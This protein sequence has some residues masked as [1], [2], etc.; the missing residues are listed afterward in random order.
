MIT[1]WLN[2]V[3]T[4]TIICYSGVVYDP[5]KPSTSSVLSLIR[6]T[7]Q[8]QYLRVTPGVYAV[9]ERKF[10]FPEVDHTDG[11]GTKAIY[12]WKKKTF[13][14]A[15]LDSLA[16]NLNDLLLVGAK[17]YKLQNHLVLPKDDS[18]I[19]K[20]IMKTLVAECK[21]RE[22]AITGGET[23]VHS[24]EESFDIGITVSGFIRK[25]ITN[26]A[27]AEDIVVGLKSNGLHS[28][29]FTQVRKLFGEKYRK[30]FIYPTK[31][32]YD[33]LC[34]LL[35]EFSINGRMHITG[36]AFTKLKT[37]IGENEEI[38]IESPIKPQ[39]IFFEMYEKGLSNRE[40]YT[41]FNCGTGFILTMPEKDVTRFLK[42]VSYA[43]IIGFI[44][45]GRGSIKIKSSFN[46]NTVSL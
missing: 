16:M 23:S 30:E 46:K 11:I 34:D 35:E 8:T 3:C 13:K 44:Q 19:I 4:A 14:N 25:I 31:L 6:S 20:K 41:T 36:G 7:W 42:K 15:V 28:N 24:N 2:T 33:D 17:A 22:I 27:K 10:N 12:H 38:V 29:G 40:M 18:L 39:K 45:R 32:Y 9:F 5:T 21:K 43:R 37:I 1:S 26:K